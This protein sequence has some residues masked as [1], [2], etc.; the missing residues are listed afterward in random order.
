MLNTTCLNV[1]GK[2]NVEKK[3][4]ILSC[5]KFLI[6]LETLDWDENNIYAFAKQYLEFG[7]FYTQTHQLVFY[8]D[9][10]FCMIMKFNQC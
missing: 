3:L 7:I 8:L 4:T 9:A 1:L 10:K 6:H 5:R 2:I